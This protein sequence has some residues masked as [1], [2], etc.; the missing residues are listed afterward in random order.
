MWYSRRYGSLRRRRANQSAYQTPLETTTTSLGH[1][2]RCL[3]ADNGSA[4]GFL[5]YVSVEQ[6][7]REQENQNQHDTKP[8]NAQGDTHDIWY[9]LPRS[10]LFSGSTAVVVVGLSWLGCPAGFW[11]GLAGLRAG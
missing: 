4:S 2:L 3:S 11:L 7:L 6:W 1:G 10:A 5:R 8:R 9:V